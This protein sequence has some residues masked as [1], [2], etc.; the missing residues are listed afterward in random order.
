MLKIDGG[1]VKSLREANGLTQ[2]YLAT[3]VDVTT[4]TISRWENKRYPTIKRE[5]ALK[6]AEALEVSLSEI[7][8]DSDDLAVMADGQSETESCLEKVTLPGVENRSSW[9]KRWSFFLGLFLL[10]VVVVVV[11]GAVWRLLPPKSIEMAAVRIVPAHAV[12]G[13]LFPVVIKVDVGDIPASFILREIIPGNCSL[14]VDSPSG[15][16]FN[17]NTGELKWLVRAK[18]REVVRGYMLRSSN[19]LKSGDTI[20]FTGRVTQRRAKGE[21]H[22]TTGRSAVSLSSYHWVDIDEN[23]VIDDEEI[24][25]VYDDY[26]EIKGVPLDMDLIEELWFGSGYSWDKESGQFVVIP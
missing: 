19:T 8:D 12:P 2:L 7:L 23:G 20:T 11:S 21:A 6:L 10:V 17:S 9:F 4:D 13:M 14:E 15:A 26:N 5:N 3:A 22:Q 25:A 18:N 24:L 1:K 16:V